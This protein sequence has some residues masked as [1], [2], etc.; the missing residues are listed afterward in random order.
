MVNPIIICLASSANSVSC[1]PLI[2]V[3]SGIFVVKKTGNSIKIG[4]AQDLAFDNVRSGDTT[5]NDSGLTITDGPSVTKAGIDA[6]DKKVS[7]VA[8][9]DVSEGSNDAVTGGQLHETNQAVA[10]NK[11]EIAGNKAAIADNTTAIAGNTAAINDANTEIGKGINFGD[12][13]SSNKFALGDTINVKGDANVLSTA[14]SEGVQLSLASD[15]TA[16][17]LT[18]GNSKL[19]SDGLTITG[20]PS[21]T[22]AGIDAG[23]KKISNIAAGDL[24]ADSKDVVTGGQ[25]FATNETVAG[26]TTSIAA[27]TAAIA[28]HTSAIA[29]NADAI[30]AN[31]AAIT[32]NTNA[33]STLS[34][35]VG[36][37]WNLTANGEDSSKVAAGD[38]VDVSAEGDKIVVSKT[39]NSIRIGLAQD[40]AFD[41]V[42]SGDTTLND[43][44][45]TITD[46][47]SVTKAG[48]DAGDK[49]VSNVAAGDVS[50][51]STDAVT[52]GQLHET[53]EQVGANKAAIA[54]N[55]T[56]IAGNTAAISNVN[57]E[58]EKGFNFGDGRTS[59]KFALGD[60]INVKGDSNV[61]STT[62]SD[63]VQLSLASDLTATSVTTGNSLLNNDGLTIADG[64]SVTSAGINAGD[65]KI[66]N[67]AA[68]DVSAGSKEVVT[69]GQ[70]HETNLKVADNA[71]AIT[72]LSEA[73][74][75][76][77]NLTA[78]GEDSSKIA[79]G[80]TVDVSADGDKIVVSKTGNSIKIGLAQDLAFSSVTTGD[81]TLNDDGLSIADGP[82]VTKAGIAAGDKKVTG[83]AAGDLS[84][85]SKDAVTGAQLFDTN[86]QVAGNKTAIADNKS[87][88][89]GNAAAIAD[90][91]TAI[92][93]INNEI[94]KGFKFG[95]GSTSN[96]F[97]LGD[98]INVKG[99]GNV[100]SKATAEG[101]E[102]SLA[103]TLNVGDE[104]PVTVDGSAGTISGLTNVT[105]DANATYSG[106]KAAT[107]EQLQSVY[108]T[109]SGVASRGWN[110]TANG[111]D[112]SNVAPG[113]TVDFAASD[114][115]IVVSKSGNGVKFGL[116]NELS[117]NSV[118]TGNTRIDNNGL[119]IAG[120]PSVTSAGINAGGA[121]V[122]NVAAGTDLTDAV[123]VGQ[124]REVQNLAS[125]GWKI[126]NA[127]G[128][129][130][131]VT[132]GS[133]VNF[134]AGN[135]STRVTVTQENGV[136]R[137]EVSAAPSPL[138]Y[139][140][141]Q[142]VSS[143]RARESDDPFTPTNE[144]TL[145]GADP[146]AP[147][148]LNNVA[149]AKLSTD[150]LQAVN[151]GQVFVLGESVANSLGGDSVFNPDTGKVEASLNVNG[152]TY[153]NV[154]DA[155]NNISAAAGAG[156]NLQVNDDTPELVAPGSVVGIK[157]G[158]NI[159]LERDGNN[160]TV[161]AFPNA[162]FTT[163]NTEVV[164]ARDVEV[165]G[166]VGVI[167]GPALSRNG[168]DAAGTTISNVAPGKNGTDAVN[169]NQL[170]SGLSQLDG[171]IQRYKNDANGGTAAAMAMA[172]LPQAYLPGKS[173]F[174]IGGS[175][176]QGQGG[177]AA[178]LSTVTENGKWVIKGTVAGSTRGQVGGS[179][180]VGYQ[181]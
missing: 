74:G 145:Y 140:G 40:L 95:D 175:T 120:G 123:N 50:E 114:S 5:L 149:K 174:A 154:N 91:T 108:N 133:R 22:S 97:A 52:G 31:A 86:E 39:G 176:F 102:L 78:N 178:G 146:D 173:M 162:S 47:P 83:V 152:T 29:G 99:D 8:A 18:T 51:G 127:N 171:R 73:V 96:T 134:V 170:N 121:K 20:G 100:L 110:L 111:A 157:A 82:S 142:N 65:K 16:D 71:S 58:L 13:N 67:I 77:W 147:V 128:V 35:S 33:L 48:I 55:K 60:T 126:G 28:D 144:V 103:K 27:N 112:S 122:T 94:G 125:A 159:V 24:R 46:G 89:A 6:G 130:G 107:Q 32:N 90:H 75:K 88:I 169:V 10:D 11:A 104:N 129:V 25:L 115:N 69:G 2:V 76:G 3:D 70:L 36:K 1:S 166:S 12:G 138:R 143:F 92:T 23:D 180:G 84:A 139:T 21:V 137:V 66:T 156:W 72:N 164:S 181:W 4:L 79:A 26:H 155:L 7:N 34:E 64:P 44:G 141:A 81:T 54:D 59:N 179:V 106:G 38:T 9:G 43:S 109:V 17:S 42:R 163:V 113:D 177:Y 19:N 87:A 101:V 45:L 57:A 63:G 15:L 105:F 93:N 161:S 56:A 41:S 68:G 80:D 53:N 85:D 150:S 119:T 98:T 160:I 153:S 148:S 37:G 165:S 151:G 30:A 172:G 116:A 168:I 132:P 14:T 118:V 117:V 131:Q 61:L 124:L 49:K 135:N 158:D 136:S 167:D 62:T